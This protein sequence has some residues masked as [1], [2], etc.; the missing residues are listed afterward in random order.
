MGPREE[1]CSFS[2]PSQPVLLEPD[3]LANT[4][5]KTEESFLKGPRYNILGFVGHMASAN[6]NSTIVV[7]KQ[8]TDLSKRKGK[9]GQQQSYINLNCCSFT[10]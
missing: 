7:Q 4:I 5:S 6:I 3:D 10:S 9:I 2:R 8:L 1:T